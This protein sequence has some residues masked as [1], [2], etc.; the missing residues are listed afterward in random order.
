MMPCPQPTMPRRSFGGEHIGRTPG[1]RRPE[2]GI[3][4]RVVPAPTSRWT[5]RERLRPTCRLD[6]CCRSELSTTLNPGE[7]SRVAFLVWAKPA[8]PRPSR[9]M[10]VRESTIS[11]TDPF[12]NNGAVIGGVNNQDIRHYN[13]AHAGPLL[14]SVEE[15]IVKGPRPDFYSSLNFECSDDTIAHHYDLCHNKSSKNGGTCTWPTFDIYR[16]DQNTKRYL[17]STIE[18]QADAPFPCFMTIWP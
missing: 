5:A 6:S 17:W 9:S 15:I 4:A 11:R 7:E 18:P 16:W 10:P 13:A 14:A 2:A 12:S 8:L 1:S 3:A